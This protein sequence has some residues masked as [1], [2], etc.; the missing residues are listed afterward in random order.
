MTMEPFSLHPNDLQGIDSTRAVDFMRKLLWAEA[1][2]VGVGQH[3]FLVP[4]NINTA[5]G[6]LDATIEWAEPTDDGVIPQGKSGFQ[7][8]ASDLL[9]GACVKELHVKKEIG[10]PLSPAVKNL[11]D[12]GG[13]Y[14][15][16][17]FASLT[18]QQKFRREEK[19]RSH[20]ESLGYQSG[21]VRLYTRD[22]LADMAGRFPAIIVWQKGISWHGI[23]H[24][25][26]SSNR[27]ISAPN[28]FV[29]NSGRKVAM[30]AI[31]ER[32]RAPGEECPVFRLT[33]LPGI[34]K[35]RFA[36]E[37]LS[38][39]DLKNRVIYTDATRFLQSPLRGW[40]QSNDSVSA[41]LVVD[42]CDADAHRVL[43]QDFSSRGPRLAVVT[44][45]YEIAR[46]PQPTNV[47]H[48]EPLDTESIRTILTSEFPGLPS[49]VVN[50]LADF[51]D[52]FPRIAYLLATTY[53]NN[54]GGG[55][56]YIQISDDLLMQRLIGGGAD[57]TS[58]WYSKQEKVLRGI[59]LFERIGYEGAHQE[60]ESRWLANHLG[61]EWTDFQEVVH[62]QKQRG[63]LQGD[64]YLYITPFM[65]KV[66]LFTKWWA[67][68]V[69]T[70]DH[71]LRLVQSI[72]ASF[73]SDLLNRLVSMLKY[74][75]QVS[76][77]SEFVK[78]LLETDGILGDGELLD[79]DLGGKLFLALTDANPSAAL[80]L[81][82]ATVG[83][84]DKSILLSFKL[85]RRYVIEALERI[86][87]WREHFTGA[88]RILLALAEAENETWANNASGVFTQLF[89]LGPGLV[90]PTEAPPLERF[91]I[92]EE[93]LS[94]ESAE[95]RKL[96]IQACDSALR[97]TNWMRM[98]G[99]ENQ[100]L[101]YEPKLWAPQTHGEIYEAY[102]WVWELL[103]SSLSALNEEDSRQAAQVLLK[104][105]QHLATI[106]SL[107]EEVI[108][109]LE[110]LATNQAV[111]TGLLLG[112]IARI[113]RYERQNLPD[114]NL[115]RWESL[116]DQLT[117]SDY[118]SRMVRYVATQLFE[119]NFDDHG[120]HVDQKPTALEQL[121]SESLDNI[122][123]FYQQ[124]R[125]L[126]TGRAVDGFR[127]GG[128]L[129][130]HDEGFTLLS[131]IVRAQREA[132]DDA[133]LYFLSGYFR[134][135]SG[136]D[137][138]KW[139][140]EIE[141]LARGIDT[142]RW[143]LELTWRSDLPTSNSVSR[144]LQLASDGVILPQDFRLF[145]YGG[146]VRQLSADML[147]AWI[148]FLHQK[149]EPESVPISAELFVSYYLSPG[150]HAEMDSE[151][152]LAIVTNEGWFQHSDHRSFTITEEHAWNSI[153]KALVRQD[154]V[155]TLPLAEKT[156]GCFGLS[157]TIMEGFNPEG[158]SFLDELAGI[159]PEQ[160]W[161][162]TI[163]YLGPPVD[164]RSF[165]IRQ[166]LRGVSLIG[167]SRPSILRSI[168]IEK[169]WKWVD[170][171]V[172]SRAW[173]LASFVPNSLFHKPDEVCLAREVLVRYGD[174][175]DVLRNFSSNYATEV[176]MG[177]GSDH[178]RTSRA[179]L[180]SLRQ[181]ETDH[182]VLRWIASYVSELDYRIEQ[183]EISEERH[184][185]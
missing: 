56:D 159:L 23:S 137:L 33:G 88:S 177:S 46:L 140:H 121:A 60:A 1:A 100:G 41:I 157:G 128:L 84:W 97:T 182:N 52:G 151:L 99:A 103:R 133:S 173:Y 185:S 89:S 92:V 21:S 30:E 15:L 144:I 49:N 104:H 44:M 35:T 29:N 142:R 20:L 110:E 127:F 167:E 76:R 32:L 81:L 158:Q 19:L 161:D 25:T 77:G 155:E 136:H 123:L 102:R 39:D 153:A 12:A 11:L 93:A 107:S 120:N 54:P 116:R 53:S 61:V 141:T 124:L 91:P 168:P 45:S 71:F 96:A 8:K 70:R 122:D 126:T 31:W 175:E 170:Q 42:E 82:Q 59:A 13:T 139:E 166:W 74:L 165:H 26:W 114:G 135:L 152:A 9:P 18:S 22:Q 129:A 40:L 4:S 7:I 112:S 79:S 179:S 163:H 2:R 146:A 148:Q 80:K 75:P 125:W 105:S 156:L 50:R 55:E 180:L 73:R 113:L 132:Q 131:R 27:D 184:G 87:I 181:S 94:S 106:D 37:T 58:E 66:E 78:E 57:T 171:D 85:G 72:P 10:N 62:Y 154:P 3:L 95:A 28:S 119:D 162:L 6:G 174:R 43:V 111:D 69:P 98:A 108:H 115:E 67:I 149:P 17:L 83:T 5:D 109:T 38:P 183:A 90:A 130:K 48:L 68:Q 178:H 117:G 36:F 169:I 34:G 147:K 14:V 138:E 143:V 47:L 63:L 101:R 118:E 176:W 164:T 150:S 65:L 172:D 145:R 51:A 86:A 160:V 24:A 134:E 64:H 16:V